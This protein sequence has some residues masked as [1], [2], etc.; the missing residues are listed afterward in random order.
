MG[1]L[2]QKIGLLK[3]RRQGKRRKD[4]FR[5]LIREGAIRGFLWSIKYT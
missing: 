5:M 3:W 2:S 4:H 1:K